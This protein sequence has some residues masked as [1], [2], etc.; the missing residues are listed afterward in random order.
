MLWTFYQGLEA[1]YPFECQTAS[2]NFYCFPGVYDGYKF[3]NEMHLDG[4]LRL[5]SLTN[6]RHC[7][8]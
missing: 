2:C 8:N 5:T 6:D 4:D 1:I 3:R 7:F